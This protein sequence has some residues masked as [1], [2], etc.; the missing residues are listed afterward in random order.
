VTKES[1]ETE[2]FQ[3]GREVGPSSHLGGWASISEERFFSHQG[4]CCSER[5]KVLGIVGGKPKDRRHYPKSGKN[6]GL[7]T[8]PGQYK[9][10]FLGF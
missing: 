3:K 10:E 7:D 9:R 1:V 2:W 6:T 8:T 4:E 5:R